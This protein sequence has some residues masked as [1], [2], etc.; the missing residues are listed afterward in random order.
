MTMRKGCLLPPWCERVLLPMRV[1]VCKFLVKSLFPHMMDTAV[2]FSLL[3]AQV[4]PFLA[5]GNHFKIANTAYVN[6][7]EANLRDKLILGIVAEHHLSKRHFASVPAGF[8]RCS[9]LWRKVAFV[10]FMTHNSL[11]IWGG[12]L[13]GISGCRVVGQPDDPGE[14]GRDKAF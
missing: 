11:E 10:L 1:S 12:K 5:Q 9:F 13:F 2:P 7:L 14:A 6:L 3:T 8:M 4:H